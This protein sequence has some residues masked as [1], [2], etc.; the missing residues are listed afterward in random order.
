MH[1]HMLN[2]RAIHGF[3][4]FLFVLL[5]IFRD[6]KKK[7]QCL[8]HSFIYAKYAAYYFFSGKLVFDY[9]NDEWWRTSRFKIEYFSTITTKS[10]IKQILKILGKAKIWQFKLDSVELKFEQKI[11]QLFTGDKE[12]SEFLLLLNIN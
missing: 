1:S 8:G 10:F 4:T 12:L 9:D 7:N 5:Q 11:F 6:T 2:I 3:F